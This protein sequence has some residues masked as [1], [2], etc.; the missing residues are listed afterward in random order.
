MAY[1]SGYKGLFVL[2]PYPVESGGRILNDNFKELADRSGPPHTAD[3]Y[4]NGGHDAV[5]SL[6]IG[7]NLYANSEWK[8]YEVTPSYGATEAYALSTSLDHTTGSAVWFTHAGGYDCFTSGIEQFDNLDVSFVG[9]K[10]RSYNHGQLVLGTELIPVQPMLTEMTD[11]A[12]SA[13]RTFC[14]LLGE[15][16]GTKTGY[17]QIHGGG[18]LTGKNFSY[19][20]AYEIASSGYSNKAIMHTLRLVA[21]RTDCNAN[22]AESAAWDVQWLAR[23][24]GTGIVDIVDDTVPAHVAG[25]IDANIA[26]DTNGGWSIGVKTGVNSDLVVELYG[27]ANKVVYWHGELHTVEIGPVYQTHT[28][29]TIY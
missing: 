19:R 28:S 10:L 21:T 2:T 7:I 12:G 29:G 18:Q 3:Y 17:L 14:S 13:Q 16:S 26:D 20:R 6:G 4:P 11:R 25:L 27:E 24:Y 22:H 5:D 23:T 15:S 8:V 9:K 1:A